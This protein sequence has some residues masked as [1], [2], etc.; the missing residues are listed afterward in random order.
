MIETPEG[1]PYLV[2][3]WSSLF[4]K[5]ATK[6]GIPP[7]IQSRDT[8]SGAATEAELVGVN[9]GAIRKM[10]GHA[11]QITTQGYTRGDAILIRLASRSRTVGTKTGRQ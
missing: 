3:H 4:R 11:D 2:R 5:I 9:L 6:A 10:L 8:R 7:E 1:R